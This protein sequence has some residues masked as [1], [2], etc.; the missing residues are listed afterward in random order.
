MKM[1]CGIIFGRA[2][3]HLKSAELTSG[4]NVGKLAEN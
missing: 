4:I 3:Q 2:V 1:H